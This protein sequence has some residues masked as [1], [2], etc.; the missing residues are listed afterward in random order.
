MLVSFFTVYYLGFHNSGFDCLDGIENR[1]MVDFVEILRFVMPGVEGALVVEGFFRSF[2][3]PWVSKGFSA[4]VYYDKGV[5]RCILLLARWWKPYKS[6]IFVAAY[7]RK[8]AFDARIILF[9]IL[10]CFIFYISIISFSLFQFHDILY[11]MI[12]SLSHYYSCD[13]CNSYHSI[14]NHRIAI[15]CHENES[16]NQ[17]R[18]G[19]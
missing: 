7:P 17:K 4:A 15:S 11:N 12:N 14:S 13:S 19:D 16:C 3:S 5:K 9:R 1:D 8:L 2:H 10:L 6:T 18:N